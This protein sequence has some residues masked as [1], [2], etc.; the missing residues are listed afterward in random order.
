MIGI[1]KIENLINHKIYIG[2]SKQIEYRW[3]QHIDRSKD[4]KYKT[5][6]YLAI[7][8]YGLE[9]FKFEIIEECN[10]DKLNE[11]EKYWIAYYDST[12]PLKGYNN[13]NG[14]EG[15]GSYKYDINLIKQKWENGENLIF[16][17]EELK[18][19]PKTVSKIL[20]RIGIYSE[21]EILKRKYL[22]IS[23]KV[24][25]YDLQGVFLKEFNSL[26]QASISTGVQ[27]HC[28]NKCCNKTYKNAGNFIWRFYKKDKLNLEEELAKIKC[29]N[30][31]GDFLKYYKS[32][33]EAS[34]DTGVSRANI[35]AACRKQTDRAGKFQWRYI[36]DTTPL[37]NIPLKLIC[38]YDLNNNLIN[39]FPSV[40]NAANITKI[41]RKVIIRCLEK[42]PNI[43]DKFNWKYKEDYGGFN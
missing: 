11:K 20:K 35:S 25:Q 15:G 38:Q 14:G 41:S 6:L 23:K 42:G 18:C 31:K 28:I 19:N 34:E 17:S 39:I 10:I 5:H 9:N 3:K 43:T 16:I 22:H 36:D 7:R 37:K 4:L 13:T 27:S 2:Q 21:E 24:Y 29:Y 8:K 30:L 40:L 12:N 26:Y 32:F 1:Y 33:I